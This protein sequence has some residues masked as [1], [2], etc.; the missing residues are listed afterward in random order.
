MTAPKRLTTEPLRVRVNLDML[1]EYLRPSTGSRA[2][3]DHARVGDAVA[4]IRRGIIRDYSDCNGCAHMDV[5]AE[6]NMDHVRALRTIDVG[7]RCKVKVCTHD[8]PKPTL[9]KDE[10]EGFGFGGGIKPPPRRG[11]HYIDDGGNTF[12][13]DNGAW[14]LK[15]PFDEPVSVSKND[16]PQTSAEDA[17]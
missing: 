6:E 2:I 5:R 4:N 11:D 17:W 1:E 8:L 15:N 9:S 14:Q 12:V 7:A 3:T 16:V 10:Y 13:F